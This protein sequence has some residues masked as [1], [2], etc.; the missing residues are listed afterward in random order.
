[1]VDRLRP[2]LGARGRIPLLVGAAVAATVAVG[3][4][5]WPPGTA[6]SVLFAGL[7]GEEGGRAIGELQKLNIP[8]RISDG[9]RL[10][11][12]PQPDV[13]FARLELAARGIP[14]QDGDQ[15]SLLDN[16]SLGVSPFVEH[17]H[18]VRAI[19][20]A[21]ART[22][23][24]VNGV[25]AASVKLALPK[26]SDF[27][28]DTPKPSAA[29]MIRLQPGLQLTTA[30]IDGLVGLVAAGVP[31]LTRDRVTLVD[32]SGRVLNSSDNDP[33]QQ[34]P[35]Q[36]AIARA[37]ARQFEATVT[38]LLLPVLG[39]GNF[40]VS[41]DADVDF[42]RAQESS[43]KY[44]NSHV[45]SEDETLH[46]PGSATLPIGIPGA[47]SN[48][49]P[50]APTVAPGSPDQTA[51]P[52]PPPA[53]PGLPASKP[54]PPAAP[55]PD[56]HRVTNYD[57][58]RTVQSVDRPAWR[59]RALS[60]DVLV[61]NSSRTPLPAK[62]VQAI[63]ELVRSAIGA[64]ANR[65]V[66]VIDLPFAEDVGG[67]VAGE[68]NPPWWRQR[69]M[70]S[71]AENALLVIAG[72]LVLAG[73]ALPLLRLTRASL[74]RNAGRPGA[75]DAAGRDAAGSEIGRKSEP[76]I[77]PLGG[78]PR[79]FVVDPESIRALAANDPQRTA[80]VIK[81]WIARDRNDLKRTG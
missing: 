61:N 14:R 74:A 39:R 13:G 49:P 62:R 7:S 77:G 23:R 9:G 35:Q 11:Q 28:A 79:S 48:R 75:A 33:L 20:A 5:L 47:L 12:V 71:L 27:L 17:V 16:E 19:E 1:M 2:W 73:G 24:Q 65:H 10:I 40:R 36:L 67:V 21:L 56:T 30:Q 43:V 37:I 44:G 58:D 72:L 45:L 34:V 31:G 6:Y 8:Y 3:A 41:A 42:S 76:A 63:D 64:G 68:V 81:E 22:I 18:Y 69:W 25:V 55:P 32:Q 26:E 57:I 50:E 70:T 46:S 59:L 60:V 80:Q 29:V 52:A 38:D 66:T 54:E 53:P 78:S 4:M 15:W 51:Q